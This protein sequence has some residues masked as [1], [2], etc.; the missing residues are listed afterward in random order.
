ML[1]EN[2]RTIL[3]LAGIVRILARYDAEPLSKRF[4]P[5]RLLTLLFGLSADVRRLRH[6]HP[7][8]VRLRK[9]LE[10]LGPTF[11]KFGQALSTRMDAIPEE[12]GLELKR[13]QDDVPPFSFE[14]V[15]TTVEE[16]L[17]GKL[18]RLYSRFDPVP[19]ASASM[20]QVHRAV[21]SDGRDVAV[22]VMRPNVE[23][24]VEQDI[25]MLTTLANLI[26]AH[27]P[28][29]QRFQ[30]RRVVDE[31]AVTIRSEMNFLVEGTRAQRFRD[32]FK[33][34]SEMRTPEVFWPLTSRRVM[35]L[36][37]SDGIP[38][39]ELSL[40]PNMGLDAV[41]ISTNII[42]SFFKQVFRDGFFH[43]D[44]H[45]GN[46]FILPDG[47]LTILDFGIVGRVSLRDRILL[48]ELL[49]GFL[50]RNYRKVAEVHLAAGFVPRHTNLDEFE[51]ACRQIGEPIFGQPLKEISIAQLL[52]QL[53]K[54]T[55]QFAMPVQPQ[56]LL[57]Q[58]TMF[59][60]EG[61]GREINPDLNMWVLA[62]PLIRDWMIENLGPVG[63]IR[64]ARER[65]KRIKDSTQ[66]MPELLYNGLERLATDRVQIRIH[67]SSLK[68]LERRVGLGFHRQ[69]ASITGGTLFVGGAVMVSAGLSAWWYGPPLLLA[70]IYYLRGMRPVR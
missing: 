44:Q 13:L 70:A 63:K 25:G 16:G 12:I 46:I 5:L 18:D 47:S 28:E 56:L 20:A 19:V 64:E 3:R 41:K 53:F 66:M 29:W 32:N 34:D 4:F 14:I 30:V 36:E 35:T 24:V 51:D 31:F 52:A 8:E 45:P 27:I 17:N 57:L 2:Y 9:I 58:K 48:A 15:K 60:L 49:R 40:H 39:D 68:Q 55:E 6:G 10:D 23:H 1:R 7:P 11:I 50:E 62:E 67:P 21:T 43:A 42:T 54:V 65:V 69:S 37:W 22:K 59:T 61:V 38:I 33:N 26:E